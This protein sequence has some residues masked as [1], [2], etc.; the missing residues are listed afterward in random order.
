VSLRNEA[1]APVRDGGMRRDRWRSSWADAEEGA[2]PARAKTEWAARE[3]SAQVL[4]S[5]FSFSNFISWFIY[6]F[7]FKPRI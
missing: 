1:H 4:L 5:S 7:Y 3:V 2:G 6:P